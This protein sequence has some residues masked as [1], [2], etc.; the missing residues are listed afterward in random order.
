[1]QS[2]A[3]GGGSGARARGNAAAAAAAATEAVGPLLAALARM[4]R[5]ASG[6]LSRAL[7]MLAQ[8]KQL[9]GPQVAAGLQAIITAST[10]AGEH[11]T[12]LQYPQ[13]H[14][15]CLLCSVHSAA[16]AGI[17]R[18]PARH[19][20]RTN[21]VVYVHVSPLDAAAKQRRPCLACPT[22][23]LRHA[24]ATP[25]CA[26]PAAGAPDAGGAAA[27]QPLDRATRAQVAEGAW[28]VLAEVAGQ[29]P[30][31]PDWQFLRSGQELGED[32]WL[33][34]ITSRQAP[35]HALL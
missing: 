14:M 5:A 2:A 3:G 17:E 34:D 26:L 21:T 1:M 33:R 15:V 22:P 20:T 25:P 29:D 27:Q 30:A 16:K 6:C 8:R 4:G 9:Q 24:H 23:T 35:K 12:A 18:P 32:P 28:V 31:A 13:R 10:A 7:A 19:M 11:C